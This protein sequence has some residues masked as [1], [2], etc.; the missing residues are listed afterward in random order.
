MTASGSNFVLSGP[1]LG[2][3]LTEHYPEVPISTSVLYSSEKMI[4]FGS[5]FLVA[6]QVVATCAHVFNHYLSSNTPFYIV[7]NVTSAN[8]YTVSSSQCYTYTQAYVPKIYPGIDY[9]LDFCFLRLDREVDS[10]LGAYPLPI[11][12][13]SPFSDMPLWM[14]GYPLG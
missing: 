8:G 4:G 5:G 1:S 13:Y 6:P 10:A 9:N 2:S 3:Q 14:L 12:K 11:T 7:F